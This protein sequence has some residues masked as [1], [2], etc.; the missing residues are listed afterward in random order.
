VKNSRVNASLK[1]MGDAASQAATAFSQFS[2]GKLSEKQFQDVLGS[3]SIKS[4]QGVGNYFA[5]QNSNL[6]AL[7]DTAT[8]HPLESIYSF[9]RSS[10][11]GGKFYTP[12]LEKK[13]FADQ[14]NTAATQG[15]EL[16]AKLAPQRDAIRGY[17][18]Q[19]IQQG[20]S[21]QT[22]L[23]GLRKAGVSEQ[24]IATAGAGGEQYLQ[25]IASIQANTSDEARKK[26]LL[27]TET[28]QGVRSTEKEFRGLE[29]E[30]QLRKK[31][32][33]AVQAS[34]SKFD[35]FIQTI[36]K[37]GYAVDRA[38][39]AQQKYQVGIESRIENATNLGGFN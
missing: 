25:Q 21:F 5:A 34:N 1:S 20:G 36:Q 29:E 35:A 18:T 33:N 32:E 8:A 11:A 14:Q 10:G 22:A 31:L 24:D 13:F 2:S 6:S 26:K 3:T 37:V 38:K 27:G 23:S 30:V 7:K 4:G 16:F 12:D 9:F 15:S 28:A 17:I 39:D 19:K